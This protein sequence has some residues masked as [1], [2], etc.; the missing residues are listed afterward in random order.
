[1]ARLTLAPKIAFKS[2]C[3]CRHDHPEESAKKT[4]PPNYS[5]PSFGAPR[6][7]RLNQRKRAC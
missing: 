4:E 6:L 2:L 3:L 1:M 7:L 5:W